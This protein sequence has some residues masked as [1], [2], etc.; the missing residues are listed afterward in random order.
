M[1]RAEQ[2][3]RDPTALVALLVV[4][5]I[6]LWT[7]APTLTHRS[8]PLDVVEGYM[9]GREWVIATYK[10]PALPSW[11]LE[12]S[13]VLT[14]A[15]G[16]PAYLASQLF[17]AATFVFVFLLGRDMMDAERAAA[18]TLL[19][20]GIAF[21][22]WP[23]PEFN[24]NVA[25]T[26]FWA[27]LPWALWRAVERG[28]VGW[29][30]LAGLLAAGGL[31]AKLTTALLVAALAGWI[32]WDVRA[33]KCLATPGPWI[34]LAVFAAAAAPLAIWL[35]AH[36]FLPLKYAADRGGQTRVGGLPL[37]LASVALNLFG[38]VAMLA[39]ARLVG[40]RW[41]PTVEAPPPP[42][43]PRASAYLIAVT[44]GPLAI[45]IVA[46]GLTGA[47]LK[48]AW[49]SSMFNFAG[50]LAVALASDRFHGAALRRIAVS[51]AVVLVVLPAGY[52]AVV[53]AG[54]WRAGAPVRVTWPQAAISERLADVWARETGKPLR[55]VAGDD[56]IAGLVGVTARDKPSI[57]SRGNLA[58]SPWI[59]PERIEREGML[60]VWNA[61]TRRIP[62]PLQPLLQGRP[63]GEER[64]HWRKR[65]G[66]GDLVVGYAIVRP[67]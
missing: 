23:T 3:L 22:A 4:G 11:V 18:G 29:W 40:P 35:I 17:I 67:K 16:W 64:F 39:M 62:P 38:L 32:M 19:L 60:I 45:A 61:A 33:R 66:G 27:A 57:L 25:E 24:H 10:H 50:L 53:A 49:G 20:T 56:W 2:I 5:Q 8:P 41:S 12:A 65:E 47:N 14:G 43:A 55:I 59:T 63:T 7:L 42:I 36:D 48:S 28:R 44:G 26:P 34:G 13:R 58:Y 46:A 54:P 9:W 51:A 52:A 1:R 37:F 21:Y 6:V 30:A 15:V 31:Y